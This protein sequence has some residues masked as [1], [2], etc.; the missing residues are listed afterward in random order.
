MGSVA[1]YPSSYIGRHEVLPVSAGQRYAY[2]SIACY[3]T[4]FDREEIVGQENPYK[5][6]M[7]NLVDEATKRAASK[8]YVL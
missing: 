2:L 6:W 8:K 1:I 3:G 7:P 5:V 4:S